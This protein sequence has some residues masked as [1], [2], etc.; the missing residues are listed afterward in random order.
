MG[1]AAPRGE[2]AKLLPTGGYWTWNRLKTDVRLF[3]SHLF[4]LT[5]FSYLLFTHYSLVCLKEYALR[6]TW[7]RL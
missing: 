5:H 7:K 2:Q 4:L 6:A 1:T 3:L